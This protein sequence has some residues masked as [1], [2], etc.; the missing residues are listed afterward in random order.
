MRLTADHHRSVLC[1]LHNGILGNHNVTIVEDVVVSR[2]KVELVMLLI[3]SLLLGLLVHL[4]E[5]IDT[6]VLLFH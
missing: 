2:A 5:L 3:T 1:V 6:L 4:E